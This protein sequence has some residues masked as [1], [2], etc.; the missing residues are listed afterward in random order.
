MRTPRDRC[1]QRLAV[2]H[3]RAF[4]GVLSRSWSP[5]AQS[6]V[7]VAPAH[8][9]WSTVDKRS[10][11]GRRRSVGGRRSSAGRTTRPSM[12]SQGPEG[13]G[14]NSP[15]HAR[16]IPSEAGRMPAGFGV[17]GLQGS[18]AGRTA[19]PPRSAWASLRLRRAS[20]R[21]E[22]RSRPRRPAQRPLL[23]RRAAGATHLQRCGQLR[24]LAAAPG[25]LDLTTR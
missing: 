21:P 14:M 9:S 4:L 12:R 22:E 5:D 1:A 24:R 8:A 2:V 25:E 3:T 11:H 7:L 13:A 16:P 18:K 23:P 10:R 15:T 20:P 17:P 6:D 19:P